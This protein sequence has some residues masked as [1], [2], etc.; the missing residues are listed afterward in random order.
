MTVE[1]E[2]SE[3]KIDGWMFILEDGKEVCWTIFSFFW[4]KGL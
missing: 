2:V 4:F 3:E 1:R